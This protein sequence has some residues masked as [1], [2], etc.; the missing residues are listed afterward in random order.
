MFFLLILGNKSKRKKKKNV[1]HFSYMY[2][3]LCTGKK[4]FVILF[5]NQ[6]FGCVV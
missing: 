4:E 2:R 6:R 3:A 1:E 5:M